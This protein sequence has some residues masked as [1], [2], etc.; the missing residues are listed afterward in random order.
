[1]ELFRMD[2]EPVETLWSITLRRRSSSLIGVNGSCIEFNVLLVAAAEFVSV[3]AAPSPNCTACTPFPVN[4]TRKP[5]AAAC[6][7]VLGQ[8][9]AG[10]PLVTLHLLHMC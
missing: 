5:I 6:Q 10:S 9:G 2:H 1:M 3:V 8:R 4:R 7:V